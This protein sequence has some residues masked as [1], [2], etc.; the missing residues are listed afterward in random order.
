MDARNRCYQGRL[1]QARTLMENEELQRRIDG[2]LADATQTLSISTG[3][4]S[5]GGGVRRASS[6]PSPPSKSVLSSA[7]GSAR[8]SAQ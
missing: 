4:G 1:E 2:M 6:F 5:G 7:Q 8:P 3:G